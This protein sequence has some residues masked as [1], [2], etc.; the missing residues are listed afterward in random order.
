MAL[1]DEELEAL[2]PQLRDEAAAF[3][4]SVAWREDDTATG[5]VQ[6]RIAAHRAA[7]LGGAPS[8][9]AVDCTIEGPAGP[10]RLRTFACEQ[11]YG[12][13]FHIHGGAW[14]AGSPEIMDQLEVRD[15]DV[16]VTTDRG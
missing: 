3:V 2:R 7:Q 6:D 15:A 14:M 13:L 9:R 16:K 5:S 12:V 1:W 10:I 8:N 4:A 11:P